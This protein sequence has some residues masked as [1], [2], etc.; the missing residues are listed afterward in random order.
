MP[1]YIFNLMRGQKM[2]ILSG[3]FLELGFTVA[4]AALFSLIGFVWKISHKVSSLERQ[5][6][7]ETRIRQMAEKELRR[8]I[9]LI[10]DNV[11]KNREWTTNRMMSIVRDIPKQ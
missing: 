9:D 2:D 11:D 3:H 7:S 4:S 5:L 8:D 10:M 1:P 6:A